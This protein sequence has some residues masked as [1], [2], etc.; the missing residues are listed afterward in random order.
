MYRLSFIWLLLFF[1]ISACSILQRQDI[2]GEKQVKTELSRQDSL[3]VTALFID[4]KKEDLLGN[5]QK[6]ISLYTRVLEKNP[7]HDASLFELARIYGSSHDFRKAQEYA[8]KAVKA[9]PEN[10]WYR[11]V[12]ANIAQQTGQLDMAREQLKWLVKNEARNLEYYQDWY[13]LERHA[14]NYTEALHILENIEQIQGPSESILLKKT[15]MYQETGNYPAAIDALEQLLVLDPENPDYYREI[16]AMY[17]QEDQYDKA[18]EAIERFK[19]TGKDRGMAN[20]LLSDQH[21]IKGNKEEAFHSLS[22]AMKN[23]ELSIDAKVNVLMS[24]YLISNDEEKIEQAEILVGHVLKAHPQ[25]PVAWALKGDLHMQNQ[26]FEAAAEAFEKVIS[27]DKSRYA[28][29]QQTLRLQMHLEAYHKVVAYADTAIG[30]FPQEPLFYLLKGVA[31]LERQEHTQAAETFNTG[32]YFTA[33]KETRADFYSHLGEAYHQSGKHEASDQAFENAIELEPDNIIVLNNYAYYLSLRKES[34]DKAL[35]MSKKTIDKYPENPTFLD[36][37]GWILFQKGQ[38]KKAQKALQAALK[39][40]G[41]NN[42]VILE[43]YGDC[44]MKL[45]KKEEA[46]QYWKRAKEISDTPEEINK[47]IQTHLSGQE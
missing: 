20:L 43:H 47:K 38:Y 24:R 22:N 26:E 35:A 13:N 23:P 45:D 34:L 31:H 4:A 25:D 30:L 2:D 15:R 16:I 33:D 17:N 44:L 21:R 46:I 12:L 14:Q 3:E 32:L 28:V 36:T 29:W 42:P 9:A 41:M 8:E 39:H 10:V 40:G 37:Y 11:K 6:A 27:R 7:R 1:L 5:S 19:K 18:L